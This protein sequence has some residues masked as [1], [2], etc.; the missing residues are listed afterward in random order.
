MSMQFADLA[1]QAAAEGVLSSEELRALRKLA[2]MDGVIGEAEASTLFTINDQVEDAGPE[3]MDFFVE[4]L[5]HWLVDQQSPRGYV[6]E[7][8]SQWL[9]EHIK[10]DGSTGALTELE[11]LV[12]CFEKA[13][14]TPKPLKEFALRQM[15]MSVLNGNGPTG[16]GAAPSPQGITASAAKLMRRLIFSPG[17]ER[18]AAVCQAE[19]EMLFRIKDA[20][21]GQSNAPEWQHLFVQGVGNYLHGFGG[22]EP[23]SRDREI[24]LA[25]FLA[26][27]GEGLGGFFRRMGHMELRGGI[28]D[29][30]RLRETGRDLDTEIFEAGQMT[31]DEAG[32][33]ESQ[34]ERDG[35]SDPYERAL[36]KFISEE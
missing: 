36:L 27:P 26:T 2:W 11:L 12:R 14:S 33:L 24:A 10:A 29:L 1:A 30:M 13:V 9:M 17:S 18:P 32:W 7:A 23:L 31:A 15:E 8:Q 19:A 34:M 22:A 25:H 21:L 16:E 3:W 35:V 28:A 5:S 6:D 4:T 20:A